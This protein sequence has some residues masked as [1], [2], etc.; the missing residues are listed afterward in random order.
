MKKSLISFMLLLLAIGGVK[1]Q[2]VTVADVEALPGETISF[3]V[4]L[5]NGQADTYTSLQFDLGL[6]TGITPTGTPTCSASWPGATGVVSAKG[7]FA[8][9]EVMAGTDIEGLVSVSLKVDE[10]MEYGSYDV[11]LSNIQF[12]YGTEGAHDDAPDVTFKVNVVSMHTIILDENSTQMPASATGVIAK[13][14]RTI[15]AN[16]WSTICLP[17]A[18]SEEQVKAAFGD[19]VQLAN[20]S[21][22]SSE[23]DNDGNIIR[24]NISFNNVTAIEANHPYVIKVTGAISEFSVTGVDLVVEAE[25]TVQVGTKKADRGYFTGCYVANTLVPEDGLF[26]YGNK[27]WYSKGLT[28]MKAFRAYFELADVLTAVEEADARITML[29]EDSETNGVNDV[30]GKKEAVRCE[31]YDLQGRKIQKPA[32]G[33]YIKNGR[34]E[35]V[36]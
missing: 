21:S 16:E 14:L 36:R 9:A 23:E 20:F 35:L 8:S 27:F 26:L 31:S 34:K 33:L 3:S 17:F 6:P 15:R 2:E 29:F 24:L 11:T 30:R 25:P 28:M 5:S 32:K 1:A 13:V 18:M 22:W 12:R 4:N 10:G 7:A 19:D